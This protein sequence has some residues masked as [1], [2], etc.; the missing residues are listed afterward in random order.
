[1]RP[2]WILALTVAVARPASTAETYVGLG[3]GSRE[4]DQGTRE[5]AGMVFEGG[6]DDLLRGRIGGLGFGLSLHLGDGSA[7][8]AELRY[9]FV[10]LDLAE[11]PDPDR[12][13]LRM[14]LG[15][16]G[17]VD[18]LL[19]NPQATIV[20]SFGFR[21]SLGAIGLFRW[22]PVAPYVGGRIGLRHDGRFAGDQSLVLGA[23]L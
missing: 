18:G 14:T 17:G 6:L 2:A 20:G 8:G 7:L 22:G 3:V 19:G 21:F 4:L 11:D 15:L 9:S 12:P 10:F 23:S 13:I 16:G 1:V 5:T